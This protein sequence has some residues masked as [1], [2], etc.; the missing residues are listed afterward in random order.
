MKSIE[1]NKINEYGE[2]IIDESLNNDPF[3]FD[4]DCNKCKYSELFVGELPCAKCSTVL[5]PKQYYKP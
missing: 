3:I 1:N 2:I 4:D 5:T